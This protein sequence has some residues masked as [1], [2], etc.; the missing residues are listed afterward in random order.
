MPCKRG[1]PKQ[2][3]VHYGMHNSWGT[4]NY[5]QHPN[6]FHRH[7]HT[8]PHTRHAHTHNKHNTHT[9]THDA[10][11]THPITHT[12]TRARGGALQWV[13]RLLFP[14]PSLPV[15]SHHRRVIWPWP[16]PSRPTHP[17]QKTFPQ[18]KLKFSKLEAD[19]RNTNFLLASDPPSQPPRPPGRGCPP[20]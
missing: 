4:G 16:I 5:F 6:I 12:H 1:M 8:H 9:D 20:Q 3:H 17:H 2:L 10:H 7:T 18:G 14:L 11:D 15:R 19:F 13:S